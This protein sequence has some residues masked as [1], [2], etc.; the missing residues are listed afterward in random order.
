MSNQEYLLDIT[1]SVKKRFEGARSILSYSEFLDNLHQDAPKYCRSTAQYV[2][3]TFNA[4]GTYKVNVNGKEL[5]RFKIFDGV[6][7]TD[8]QNTWVA[9]QEE[10]QNALYRMLGNFVREG[11]VTRLMLLHGPNG[12]GK[13]SL[14]H[15]IYDA[16]ERYSATPDGAVYKFNWIFPAE[17]K[18]K[19]SGIGFSQDDK[20]VEDLP[21]YAHLEG[22]QIEARI[23]SPLKDHPLLL[24]P[25]TERSALFDRLYEEKRLPKHYPLS[26]Y[27]RTGDLSPRNRLIFDTLLAHY[28]GNYANVLRHIQVERF[29]MS[30]RYRRSIATIEPQM[31]V[32]AGVR[33]VTADHSLAALPKPLNNLSLFEP[34]GPLVDANRGVIEYSDL[35]KRPIEAFKYLLGTC[36]T[37]HVHVTPVI[38]FLDLLLIGNANEQNLDQFKEISEFTSFKSRIELFRVP[39]LLQYSTEQ[40]IYD[41]QLAE[42]SIP[43]PITP[44][45]TE[46]AALWAV[47]TRIKKPNAKRLPEEIGGHLDTFT[48]LEKALLYAEFFLALVRYQ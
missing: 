33:Q 30:Y 11:R 14:I 44:H 36:E 47:L 17:K 10:A 42:S 31:H 13:S 3:D 29:Y 26:Q 46:L 43:K 24:L 12:S 21:S 48:P 37:G 40:S 45:V 27:L 22:D 34:M 6:D 2:Q 23:T 20:H 9:G 19:G 8:V 4:F 38:L 18:I 35:L 15:A 32:D 41:K 39:Y 7:E 25:L 28:G 16:L 1:K 5:T